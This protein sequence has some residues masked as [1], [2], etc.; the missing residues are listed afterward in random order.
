MDEIIA[1]CGL[2]CHECPAYLAH[3]G[4]DDEKRADTAELWSRIYRA[5]IRPEQVDCEGCLAVGGV[6]FQHCSVCEIRK[7]GLARGV[8]N[9]AGCVDYACDKLV[10][11]FRMVPDAQAQLH[12]IRE[13]N[14]D[15][16][17]GE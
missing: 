16:H 3:V 11:F 14:H 10:E 2:R 6:L 5:K 4:D 17:E 12:A 8:A 1:V 9:C 13:S 15:T 7:C